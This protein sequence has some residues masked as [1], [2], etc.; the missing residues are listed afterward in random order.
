MVRTVLSVLQGGLFC[1]GLFAQVKVP[2]VGCKA[3]GQVG[4]KA[5][6]TGAPVLVPVSAREGAQLAYYR[7]ELGSAVLAP[8]GWNCFE[9][10]GS[11]GETMAL[12]S[13]PL[14]WNS[15]DRVQAPVIVIAHLRGSSQGRWEVAQMIARLFPAFQSFV[16]DVMETFNTPASEFPE[17]P[18]PADTLAYK[19][20]RVVVYRTPAGREGLGTHSRFK[21]KDNG[22]PIEGAVVLIGD[23]PDLLHLIV[24]LPAS[25]RWLAPAIIREVERR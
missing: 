5:A 21:L 7:S 10:Y 22:L 11:S 19:G 15:K 17:G 25:L 23:P 13:A 3:D 8:R 24:R 2:F 6:P 4:P 16:S 9:I 20:T 18:F 14:D 1:A 12:S